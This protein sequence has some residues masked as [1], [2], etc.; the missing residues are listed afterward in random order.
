MRVVI[1]VESYHNINTGEHR[2]FIV[3][4]E[5]LIAI[6]VTLTN[7]STLNTVIYTYTIVNKVS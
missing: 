7:Y 5:L 3:I 4:T 1:K 2:V 6:V